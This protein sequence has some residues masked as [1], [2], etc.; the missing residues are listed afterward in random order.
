MR[1]AVH[2]ASRF[3]FLLPSQH[4]CMHTALSYVQIYLRVSGIIAALLLTGCTSISPDIAEE[5]PKTWQEAPC[6]AVETLDDGERA[7]ADSLMKEAVNHQALYTLVGDVKPMSTLLQERYALARPDSAEAGIRE[8]VVRDSAVAA[9]EDAGQLQRV[10]DALSCGAIQTVVVPFKATRDGRRTVQALLVDRR[11]F[12]SALDRD[13][14][15]WGQWAF[16]PTSDPATVITAVEY[17]ASLDRYRGYGYLFGYP[18][19]AVTFFVEAART[20]EKEDTFVERNFFHIPTAEAETNRFTYAVPE[21]YTPSAP[22]STIYRNAADILEAYRER[23]A[24]HL[25]ENDTLQAV[26]LLRNWYREEP[27]FDPRRP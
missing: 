24:D 19:H 21:G 3:K 15:F 7:L 11:A 26:E 17:E 14:A 20:A 18:E 13:A 2:F 6:F 27:E 12:E 4:I 8:V 16:T 1:R 22:D 9:Y 5:E 10:A 23:R 25:N